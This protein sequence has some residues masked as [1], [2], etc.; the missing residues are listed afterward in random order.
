MN[1]KRFVL[2]NNTESE[3]QLWQLD[4]GECVHQLTNDFKHSQKLLADSY[5]L[6]HSKEKPLPPSW[7]SV[8]IKL[9]VSPH[10]K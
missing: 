1:N 9:G 10:Q 6:V 5:D 4:S 7:S 3:A 8:D 2:T